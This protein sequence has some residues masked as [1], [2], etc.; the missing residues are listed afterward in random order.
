MSARDRRMRRRIAA[1]SSGVSS[2]NG[3]ASVPTGRAPRHRLGEL[4]GDAG[5]AAEEEVAPPG[6]D[7]RSAQNLDRLDP[8]H[9]ADAAKAAQ[10]TDD[11]ERLAVG[12]DQEGVAMGV[13][14]PRIILGPHDAM[15][16]AKTDEASRLLR[17]AAAQA[18]L[19]GAD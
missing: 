8:G 4:G 19:D 15:R 14:Q 17:A 1:S 6:R 5:R 9:L 3:G 7:S 12:R 10:A 16:V 18:A 13:A 2:R 11:R